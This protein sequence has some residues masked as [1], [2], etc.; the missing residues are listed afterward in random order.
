MGILSEEFAMFY[1]DNNRGENYCLYKLG[2]GEKSVNE[3]LTRLDSVQDLGN[4]IKK[5]FREIPQ[6]VFL[7]NGVSKLGLP[8]I[9]LKDTGLSYSR[10]L[11]TNEME[12]LRKNLK[13]F[14]DF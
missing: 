1:L 13:D 6:K 10:P 11:S 7:Y 4:L 9:K 12:E 8:D 2:E 14:L 5:I 3:S